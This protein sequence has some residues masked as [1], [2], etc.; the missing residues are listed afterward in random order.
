MTEE[1]LVISLEE[2]LQLER[3]QQIVLARIP[4]GRSGLDTFTCEDDEDQ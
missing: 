2:L 1:P 4:H 3:E